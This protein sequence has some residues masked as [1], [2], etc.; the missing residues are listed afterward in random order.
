MWKAPVDAFSAD[1]SVVGLRV[2]V[3]V[4]FDPLPAEWFPSVAVSVLLPLLQAHVVS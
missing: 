4:R 1:V 3:P 2:Q